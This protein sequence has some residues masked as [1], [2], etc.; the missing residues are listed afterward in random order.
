[1]LRNDKKYKKKNDRP[2]GNLSSFVLNEPRCSV[3]MDLD[4][5]NSLLS[6]RQM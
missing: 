5:R 1:M 3:S 2:R 6:G 4:H